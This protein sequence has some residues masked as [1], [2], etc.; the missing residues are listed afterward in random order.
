MFSFI[1]RFGDLHLDDNG[2]DGAKPI[3]VEVD[4]RNIIIHPGFKPREIFSNNIAVVKLKNDIR[5]TGQLTVRRVLLVTK[6]TLDN[7]K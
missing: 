3:D 5:M 1:A 2:R 4:K 6:M 7:S